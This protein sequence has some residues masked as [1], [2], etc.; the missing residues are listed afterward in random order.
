MP[1]AASEVFGRSEVIR[2]PDFF[3]PNEALYQTEPHPEIFIKLSYYIKTFFICQL[4][5][6]KLTF[7]AKTTVK[8]AAEDKNLRQISEAFIFSELS[9]DNLTV[10]FID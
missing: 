3:V 7:F 10:I 1:K 6:I 5:F 2:T 4:L 8:T 9:K